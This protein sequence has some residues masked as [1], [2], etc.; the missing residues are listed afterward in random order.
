[1]NKAELVEIIANSADISKAKA[2]QALD[3]FIEAVTSSLKKGD[4][5][6][7]VGFG[8][9][10]TAERAARVGRNPA[11]GKEI[12]IAASVAPKFKPGKQLKEAV[13]KKK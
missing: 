6:T 1:M 11:T 13:A 7:L 3:G 9:F 12:K 5:V 10:S 2:N 8:T 4:N